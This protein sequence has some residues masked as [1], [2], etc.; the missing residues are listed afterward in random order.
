MSQE[1]LYPENS[2]PLP[3]ALDWQLIYEL[4]TLPNTRSK[5]DFYMLVKVLGT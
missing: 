2:G 3:Q 4:I 5:F 1:Y